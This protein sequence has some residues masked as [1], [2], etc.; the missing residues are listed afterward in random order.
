MHFETVKMENKE[1]IKLYTINAKRAKREGFASKI[2]E[3]LGDDLQKKAL[4][5]INTKGRVLGFYKDKELI[6]LYIF[7]RVENFFVKTEDSK[8]NVAGMK[9][10]L[11]AK[12]I[13]GANM[14]AYRDVVLYYPEEYIAYKEKVDDK[15]REYFSDQISMG[16]V[17]GVVWGEKL[18]YSLNVADKDENFNWGGY[19][20]GFACGFV[21][22]NL[23]FNS[24]PLGIIYGCAF[25]LIF[26]GTAHSESEVEWK[27]F[28]FINKEVALTDSK[29]KEEESEE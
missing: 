17:T 12:W 19:L 29:D 10:D 28:N 23:L 21:V 20:M 3:K 26:G 5:A 13:S 2:S 18:S 15:V 16:N 24:L 1:K 11:N 27:D 6:G 25:A 4:D 7:E 14:A 9:V 22:G 8:I